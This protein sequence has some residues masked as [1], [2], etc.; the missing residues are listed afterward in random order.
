MTIEGD[1][2]LDGLTNL[3][4]YA[5]GSDPDV[6]NAN[7]PFS[8]QKVGQTIE[9][10]MGV[11]LDAPDVELVIERSADMRS[12]QRINLTPVKIIGRIQLREISLPLEERWFFRLNAALKP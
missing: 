7:P 1:P 6:Q 2:D 3:T 5:L 8:Y 4:E 10:S 11:S 9:L 12:W